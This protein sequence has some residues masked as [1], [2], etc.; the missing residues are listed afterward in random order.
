MSDRGDDPFDVLFDDA[1]DDDVFGA[2]SDFH[3][4]AVVYYLLEAGA[5]SVEELADVVTGWVYASRGR[6]TTR[7]DR[8]RVRRALHHRHLPRLRAANLVRYDDAAD[9]VE[10]SPLSEPERALV[11]WAYRQE[12][13]G[14]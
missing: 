3:R 8:S 4:R 11:E 10:L 5:A 9:R 7:T 1:L 2:L 13:G 6:M 14:E 12:F